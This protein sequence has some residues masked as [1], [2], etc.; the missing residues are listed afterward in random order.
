LILLSFDGEAGADESGERGMGE[1]EK[2]ESENGREDKKLQG[3]AGFSERHGCGD[4]NF[5]FDKTVST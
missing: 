3:F 4:E 5:S 2:R 1:T